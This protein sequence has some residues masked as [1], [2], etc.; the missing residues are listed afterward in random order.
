M[1][2]CTWNT[3]YKLVFSGGEAMGGP[4]SVQLAKS[5]APDGQ[6]A[7]EVPLKA[8]ATAGSYTGTWKLQAEDGT[9]FGQVTVRIKVKSE[10]FSVSSVY[11]NLSDV[12]PAA[13][14]Y[15]YS[16]DISIVSSA[17]GKVTYQ[18]ETSDGA[19]SSLKSLTFD[20]AGTEVEDFT[21]SGLGVG[22]ATTD[23]W[24]KVYVQQPNNQTFGPFN[25]K[26]TCP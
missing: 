25:F 21:W 8:P 7:V 23:Y 20:A 6:I 17:A 12:I 10:A 26:V 14:P 3:N 1:G 2:T 9:Q 11:T 24:L 5:V 22:G 15:T 16:I 13:C 19:V 4:A 18:T